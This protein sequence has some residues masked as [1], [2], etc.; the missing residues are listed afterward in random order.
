MKRQ[1]GVR[2]AYDAFL[3]CVLQAGFGCTVIIDV[4]S[5]TSDNN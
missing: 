5:I 2:A 4:M 1:N 3:S